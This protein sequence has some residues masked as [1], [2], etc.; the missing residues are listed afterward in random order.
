M[1]ELNIINLT[2][3]EREIIDRYHEA[4]QR[5]GFPSSEN[6]KVDKRVNTGAGRYTYFCPSCKI[7]MADGQV[8]LG[9]Y[10]QINMDGLEAGASFW[11]YVE[12]GALQ[13]LEIVVNGNQPWDGEERK[14]TICDPETG[15]FSS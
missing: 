12:N 5:Y 14:W 1:S 13:Y 11:I 2:A 6:I 10:S 8:G 3:M 9:T 4:F 7:S 15:N